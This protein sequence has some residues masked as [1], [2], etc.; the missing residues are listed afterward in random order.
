MAYT[1]PKDTDPDQKMDQMDT[2]SDEEFF[3]AENETENEEMAEG[4]EKST[5]IKMLKFPTRDIYVPGNFW[6][7]LF[8]IWIF[9]Q[10]FNF[11]AIFT[12]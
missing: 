6:R 10:K 9:R 5:G 4:R 7:C 12:F 3:D 11:S 2:N 1:L 8:Q